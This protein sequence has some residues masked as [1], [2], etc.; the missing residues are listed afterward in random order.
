MLKEDCMD[1]DFTGAALQN[2]KIAYADPIFVIIYGNRIRIQ[3]THTLIR[4]NNKKM[5]ERMCLFFLPDWLH[6]HPWPNWPQ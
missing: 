5:Q 3:S 1:Q 6:I 4:N 2:V